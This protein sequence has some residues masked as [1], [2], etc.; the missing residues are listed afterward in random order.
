MRAETAKQAA[1]LSQHRN[2]EQRG[3]NMSTPHLQVDKR[4]PEQLG[5]VAGRTVTNLDEK[6][7]SCCLLGYAE[8][9]L[10]FWF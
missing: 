8:K 1:G 4:S 6:Q 3:G 7:F 2:I 5:Q 10:R 9:T